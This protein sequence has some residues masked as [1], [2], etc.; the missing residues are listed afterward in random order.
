MMMVHV[1][2][3]NYEIVWC[4]L[5]IIVHNWILLRGLYVSRHTSY[6]V[7]INNV[8]VSGI[9]VRHGWPTMTISRRHK[10]ICVS[11][12]GETCPVR[13]LLTCKR[14]CW[15]DRSFEG[16]S[17]IHI[18]TGRACRICQWERIHYAVQNSVV[19]VHASPQSY[20]LSHEGLCY[21]LVMLE[22]S[23]VDYSRL[24]ISK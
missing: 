19:C 6:K 9:I 11:D 20:P 8:S 16:S 14:H 21:Q 4:Y 15:H 24:N 10:Y 13:T 3:C 7:P 18:C 23:L 1:Q 12:V 2:K 5:A 17:M 22:P